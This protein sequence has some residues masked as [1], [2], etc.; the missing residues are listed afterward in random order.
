MLCGCEEHQLG[1]N[2][3][4]LSLPEQSH[5]HLTYLKPSIRFTIEVT[6]YLSQIYIIFS[7]AVLKQ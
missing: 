3:E 7:E 2:A 5:Q 6:G 4:A 1:L